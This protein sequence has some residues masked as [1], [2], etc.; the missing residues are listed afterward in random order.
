MNRE[1]RILIVEDETAFR[2]ALKAYLEDSGFLVEESGNGREGL[3][4][5]RSRPPD[6][7]LTDIRMPVMDGLELISRLKQEYP[8]LPIIAITG[9]ADPQAAAT[10][11]LGAATCLHKPITDLA[12]VQATIEDVLRKAGLE[13]GP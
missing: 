8:R 10:L 9:T 3:D 11:E 7:V 4:R 12:L 2:R 1:V 6:M 5:V 13:A